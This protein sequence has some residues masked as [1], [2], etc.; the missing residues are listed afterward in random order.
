MYKRHKICSQ[1]STNHK[2]SLRLCWGAHKELDL[3]WSKTSP[4]DHKDL[5]QFFTIKFPW[6]RGQYK[7]FDVHHNLGDSRITSSPSRGQV[8]KRNEYTEI[9]D[10]M[11]AWR[12]SWSLKR[13]AQI[14]LRKLGLEWSLRERER[15]WA[16]EMLVQSVF[17]WT[18]WPIEMGRGGVIDPRQNLPVRGVRDPDMSDIR[19]RTWSEPI[20]GTQPRHRTCSVSGL[21]PG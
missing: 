11:V 8:L 6:M 19:G 18:G 15:F 10:E 14:S 4:N 5:V 1:S 2:C 3:S 21:N 17:K 12:L 7:L 16:Q 20:F 9:V 13:M